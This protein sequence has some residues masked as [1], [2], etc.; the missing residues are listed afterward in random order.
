[1]FKRLQRKKSPRVRAAQFVTP[2]AVEAP[3]RGS[4][5][6]VPALPPVELPTAPINAEVGHTI[7]VKP[8]ATTHIDMT[9]NAVDRAVGFL[10][11]SVPLYGAF[12]VGVLGASIAL[13]DVPALSFAAFM[14]FWLSFVAA[15]LV[16]YIYTLAVSTEGIAL[17]EARQKWK[18]IREE[19]RRR[20]SHYDR[21]MEG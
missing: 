18:V 1:M 16:G 8:N 11:A 13:F 15:W 12:A 4:D 2:T 6:W 20:W 9:T 14:I 5:R 10:V 19:Q 21:I 7:N 17:F 3:L